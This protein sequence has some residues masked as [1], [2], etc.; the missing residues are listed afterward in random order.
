MGESFAVV[1]KPQANRL[2]LLVKLAISSS[3]EVGSTNSSGVDDALER[4]RACV[5]GFDTSSSLVRK[6]SNFRFSERSSMASGV[7][8]F[9]RFLALLDVE[10]RERR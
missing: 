1:F 8:R 7:K 9:K 4:D 10:E 5:D 2:R 6:I 3:Y